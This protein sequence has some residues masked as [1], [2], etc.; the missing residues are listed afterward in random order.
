M[1]LTLNIRN[2]KSLKITEFA[3]A[4]GPQAP[5]TQ[6]QRFEIPFHLLSTSNEWNIPIYW[7][8]IDGGL[9]PSSASFLLIQFR[10][11]IALM[12]MMIKMM[13]MMIILIM[14]KF[15]L[16]WRIGRSQTLAGF[17]WD[18]VIAALVKLMVDGRTQ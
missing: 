16:K 15:G 9:H 6:G 2:E 11:L 1:P 4:F 12:I 13:K 7:P 3:P 14:M 8:S 10:I 5:H 18:A 17:V